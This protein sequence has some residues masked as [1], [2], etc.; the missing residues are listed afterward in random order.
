MSKFTDKQFWAMCDAH[1]S[2]PVPLNDAD[3]S[4]P[5]VYQR[6]YGVFYVPGGCH[7]AAMSLLLAFNH[8]YLN[9]IDL[10]SELNLE[11]SSAT[12]D[13]W[14][15]ETPGAAFKSSVGKRIQ[16]GK[17]SLSELRAF[18]EVDFVFGTE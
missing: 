5:F 12:A 15:E 7:P 9:A 13:R 3:L 18:G 11:Y 4:R 2:R 6:G 14:L 16:A 17:L 8:G 10:A 1:M